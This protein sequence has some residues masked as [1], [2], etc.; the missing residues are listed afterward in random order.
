MNY[1]RGFPFYTCKDCGH[2]AW[3][4]TKADKCGRCGSENITDAMTCDSEVVSMANQQ[5]KIHKKNKALYMD[6][7]E[8]Q[9]GQITMAM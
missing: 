2:S 9:D 8:G 7:L 3:S 6:V 4:V 5:K 1:N